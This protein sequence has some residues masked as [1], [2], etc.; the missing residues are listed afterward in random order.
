[1]PRRGVMKIHVDDGHSVS[2][3]LEA[4]PDAVAG[5]VLAHGA[6]AGMTHAFIAAVAGGLVQRRIACLRFQF[7]YMEAGSKQPDRPVLAQVTVRAAVAA[8][9]QALPNIPLF[10]GGKSFGGRMTSRAQAEAPLPGVSG[11]VFWGFPL[12]P[13][14][15]PAT[16][17]AAH[18]TRI[19]V[20]MLFLQGTRDPLAEMSHLMPVITTLGQ[21]A[22]LVVAEDAD[23]A[24]HVPV[25]SGRRDADLLDN[26]LDRTVAWMRDVVSHS[27]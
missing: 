22:T 1:M 2:G 18:L 25:R 4:P 23:H 26:L 9:R 21:R 19:T 8:A 24:F 13:A 6:G 7:P 3:L 16:E 17:R 11:L 15:K 27:V 10:A 5:I 12:H 14:G 20:P